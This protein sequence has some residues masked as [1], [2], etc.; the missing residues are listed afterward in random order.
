M[1][2][3]QYQDKGKLLNMDLS[4]VLDPQEKLEGLPKYAFAFEE[5]RMFP[6]ND[7]G[8]TLVSA[9]YFEKQASQL[10]KNLAEKIGIKIAKA[11]KQFN[12]EEQFKKLA[13]KLTY[14]E[15]KELPPSAFALPEKRK[16][17]LHDENHVRAAIHFFKMHHDKLEPDERVQV[18]KA[19][20]NKAK[21]FGIEVKDDLILNL[22]NENKRLKLKKVAE[23]IREYRP[24]DYSQLADY[25]ETEPEDVNYDNL[26]NSLHLLDENFAI[27]YRYFPSPE[28][29]LSQ[30]VETPQ[31]CEIQLNTIKV[32][33]EVLDSI[34][35][36]ILKEIIGKDD[37]ENL[38]RS[39]KE[40]LE[41]WLVKEKLV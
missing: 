24:D 13:K 19:I 30:A 41:Q 33:K 20:V 11:L 12:L 21:E 35:K 38:T 7:P 15:R 1:L 27:D 3:D 6:V 32:K 37:L 28:I 22:A 29:L 18:A 10:D 17:P 39:E 8:N 4:E 14:E 16:Y 31:D 5:M 26:L 40:I 23:L 34:P 2:V 9:L 25:L 36:D